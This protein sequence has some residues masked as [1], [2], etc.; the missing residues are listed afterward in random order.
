MRNLHYMQCLMEQF[1]V[2]DN[3]ELY[4]T[5]VSCMTQILKDSET[6]KEFVSYSPLSFLIKSLS[7]D[8]VGLKRGILELLTEASHHSMLFIQSFSTDRAKSAIDHRVGDPCQHSRAS[9]FSRAFCQQCCCK[10]TC[11]FVFPWYGFSNLSHNA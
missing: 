9:F 7:H 10:N 3:V 2:Q 5:I 4:K 8:D 1:T 6:L 11:K